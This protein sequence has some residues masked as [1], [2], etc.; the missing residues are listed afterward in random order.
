MPLGAQWLDTYIPDFKVNDD[1]INSYQ[2]NSQIG[3]D[4]AG[5]F[6]IVWRDVRDNPGNMNWPQIYCQ[7]LD[8]YGSATNS[9]FKIGQ[10]TAS[11]PEI[12]VFPDGKFVVVWTR[13]LFLNSI[14]FYE[15]YYQR[16][17]SNGIQNGAPDN[18]LDTALSIS[19]NLFAGLTITSDSTGNFVISWCLKPNINSQPFIYFQRYDSSG[20]R[21]D[22]IQVVNE[23]FGY[24][25]YPTIASNKDGSFAVV[26]QDDRY[27][28]QSAYDIYMQRYNSTG[29][30]LGNNIKINDDNTLQLF[31]GGAKVSTNGYGQTVITWLDPRVCGYGEVFYQLYAPNGNPIGVNRKANNSPCG[32]NVNSPVVSMRSDRFFYIGWSEWFYSGREQFYGR[33]FDSAGNPIGNSYMIPSA[34]LPPTTQR[35]NSVFLLKDKV[36]STWSYNL[37]SGVN[38]DIYCNVRGFQNPDTVIGITNQTVIADEFELFPPFPNPFNPATNI[39][40]QISK[41]NTSVKITIYDIKGSQAAILIDGIQNKGTYSIEWNAANFSSGIYFIE[42]KAENGFK[43]IQKI[44]LI[45]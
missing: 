25:Q 14:Q 7:I 38:V 26:W 34:S 31:R 42:M 39:K 11:R 12:T 45:K 43:Q 23:D 21:I 30:K 8:K 4:S 44:I 2:T 24:A 29:I 36:Y 20:S 17:L 13:F 27:P 15:I 32:D 41:N 18:V 6:V 37:N 28:S 10:D 16:F 35:S 22:S 19:E 9:N 33:R 5:N 1:N 40:Y 3:V